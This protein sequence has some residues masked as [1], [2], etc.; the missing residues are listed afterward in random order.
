[1][2]RWSEDGLAGFCNRFQNVCLGVAFWNGRDPILKERLFGL[3]GPEGNH[4]EDVKEY[5]FHVDATPT[6]SYMHL[7]YFYPMDEYPYKDLVEGNAARGRTEPEYELVDALPEREN[8]IRK[9][10]MWMCDIEYAKASEGDICARITVTNPSEDR[11][12]RIH[13][14]PS[15]WFRNTWSWGWDSRI[16][17]VREVE[18]SKKQRSSS[19]EQETYAAAF[20]RHLGALRWAV[21]APNQ[22][23]S[24]N[25]EDRWDFLVTDNETNFV[26]LYGEEA[27]KH[28]KSLHTKDAFHAHITGDGG[29]LGG[30][31]KPPG[32]GG[33]K[34]CVWASR[35][36]KPK[37]TFQV[38][39]RFR[40]DAQRQ[41]MWRWVNPHKPQKIKSGSKRAADTAND[42]RRPELS[43]V[44]TMWCERGDDADVEG[45]GRCYFIKHNKVETFTTSLKHGKG[46]GVE[47]R[48]VHD[49]G[50]EQQRLGPSEHV[51]ARGAVL[52]TLGAQTVVDTDLHDNIRDRM[53]QRIEAEETSDSSKEGAWLPWSEF[54]EAFEIRR[55]EADEYYAVLQPPTIGE[56][57]RLIQRQAFAGLLWTKCFYHY[58][59][60]MWLDG[61]PAF[62]PPPP[63]R[64]TIRNGDWRHFFTSSVL[65]LPDKWECKLIHRE[66]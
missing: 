25:P 24:R 37:Q 30:K 22:T 12:E 47:E 44:S 5:Y 50:A 29:A 32:V 15:L 43:T 57:D 58:G 10:H 33:T 59:V 48:K 7:R 34:A 4:G 52:K 66:E 63:G 3:G 2:K 39:F 17:E 14:L 60:A 64:E 1:M 45:G 18:K 42:P 53:I 65:S 61:D 6:H 51:N 19:M 36:L 55:E 27:G 31:V 26:R 56:D 8:S 35:L 38:W 54:E 9:G 13:V 16:P 20:E 41:P 28:Q 46:G 11:T 62:P 23:C 21:G 49:I 40:V